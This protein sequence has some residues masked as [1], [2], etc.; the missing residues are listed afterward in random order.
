LY[1]FDVK[2]IVVPTDFSASAENAMFYA[3]QLATITGASVLLLH[4]YQVPVGMNDMPVLMVST[5]ELKKSADTGLSRAKELLQKNFGALDVQAESRLGD[6]TTELEDVCKTLNPF[7]IVVG[8]HGAS[9]VQRILFGSTSLSIIRHTRYPVIVV[10]DQLHNQ[11]IKN[12]ALAVDSSPENIPV[13]KINTIIG[14]LKIQLHI[15]HVQQEKTA[16][17]DLRDLDAKLN[18]THTTIYDHEFVHGIESYVRENN[19][20]LLIIFPRKHNLIERLF[21]RTHTPEL[22]KKASVPIMCVNED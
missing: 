21:F 20:D 13:Q 18:A 22:L 12:A 11:S 10:P 3:G 8:K 7:V 2:T 9:G 16:S 14:E 5:D 15:I 6:V 1:I 4:V 19:I 17:L